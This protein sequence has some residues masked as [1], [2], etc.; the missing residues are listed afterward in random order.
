MVLETHIKFCVTDRF[1][2]KKFF[3]PKNWENGP[4]AGF[5]EFIENFG[6]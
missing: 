4:K 2:R 1:S 5:F 3:C 6:Q